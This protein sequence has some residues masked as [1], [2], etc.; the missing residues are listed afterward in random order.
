MGESSFQQLRLLESRWIP[1]AGSATNSSLHAPQPPASDLQARG[2]DLRLRYCSRG[3]V[4]GI[5]MSQP[6]YR[7][8]NSL[9][10]TSRGFRTASHSHPQLVFFTTRLSNDR[11][12]GW[13]NPWAYRYT[14][15]SLTSSY[16]HTEI[17]PRE[18]R[19]ASWF[20]PPDLRN[21]RPVSLV[22]WRWNF[23]WVT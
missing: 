8:A 14:R 11:G 23:G 12:T 19:D 20:Q 13:S 7:L 18:W 6:P 3:C 21:Y 16:S 4:L 10:K 17:T 15:F 1:Q 22:V 9:A 5:S 2:I